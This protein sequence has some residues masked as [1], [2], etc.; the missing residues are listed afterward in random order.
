MRRFGKRSV[1]R[2]LPPSFLTLITMMTSVGTFIVIQI[3]RINKKVKQPVEVR[4]PGIEDVGQRK[5]D[6]RG[7]SAIGM[8]WLEQGFHR[9]SS[10]VFLISRQGSGG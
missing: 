7:Y 1:T 9:R 10:T 2:K 6:R 4:T 3:E 8:P 5:N